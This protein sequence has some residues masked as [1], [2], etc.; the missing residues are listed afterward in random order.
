MPVQSKLI[1]TQLRSGTFT[2][3][4][5]ADGD[6]HTWSFAPTGTQ[7]VEISRCIPFLRDSGNFSAENYGAETVSLTTGITIGVYGTVGNVPD[8]ALY[9]LTDPDHPIKSNAD[10]TS[11][12]YDTSYITYGQGTNMLVSRWTFAKSGQPIYLDA[13]K[14]QYLALVTGDTMT[15]LVDQHVL[16]Q[17][18]YINL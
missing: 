12:C 7:Q 18:Y 8:T 15:G 5:P 9:M 2:Q 10:W 17:G 13:A 11:Y 16:V 1:S 3:I 4:L 6:P 14:G